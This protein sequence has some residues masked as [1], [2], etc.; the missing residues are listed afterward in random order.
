MV[1]AHMQN[2]VNTILVKGSRFMAMERVVD[3][4][5]SD[6]ANA[7]IDATQDTQIKAKDTSD[8]SMNSVHSMLRY[9]RVVGWLRLPVPTANITNESDAPAL[10]RPGARRRFLSRRR[11]APNRPPPMPDNGWNG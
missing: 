4:L 2:G 10:R 3:E 8:A 5:L 9:V 1:R 11:L 7:E 6:Q